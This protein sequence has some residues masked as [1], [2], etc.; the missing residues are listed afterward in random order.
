MYPEDSNSIAQNQLREI[1]DGSDPRS[2]YKVYDNL[3][4]WWIE[5]ANCIWPDKDNEFNEFI[6]G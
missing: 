5:E 1:V 6:L 4:K 2:Y 3:Y